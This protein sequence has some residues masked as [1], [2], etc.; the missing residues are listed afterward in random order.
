[1]KLLINEIDLLLNKYSYLEKN[2]INT[3]G[4]FDNYR[5]KKSELND[6][7]ERNFHGS[8]LTKKIS[9]QVNAL[10]CFVNEKK[11]NYLKEVNILNDFSS[12][13]NSQ[14]VLFL[15]KIQSE[16]QNRI[17][18]LKEKISDLFDYTLKNKN[19]QVQ[20]ISVI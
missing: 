6:F 2:V 12:K 3:K 11:H 15:D 14:Y 9:Q 19:L 5:L 8:K 1:M 10:N 16:E 13:A 20:R 18:F 17:I 7:I 4:D